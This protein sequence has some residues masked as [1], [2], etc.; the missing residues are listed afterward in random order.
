MAIDKK[1]AW[2][3]LGL[4]L[5]PGFTYAICDLS[6]PLRPALQR[7]VDLGIYALISTIICFIAL[8]FA[9]RYHLKQFRLWSSAKSSVFGGV[10]AAA[11]FLGS[12][13]AITYI[14]V[15][16]ISTGHFFYF[17]QQ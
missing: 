15:A 4:A 14:W 7:I 2:G 9:N 17:G 3:L 5:W 6:S 1:F 11:N 13:A 16:L 12:Y 10:L 8:P